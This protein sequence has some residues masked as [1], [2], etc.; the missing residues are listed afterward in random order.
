VPKHET[1]ETGQAGLPPR[2]EDAR[3]QALALFLVMAGRGG[4][5][6]T[7]LLRWICERAL[8]AGRSALVIADGDRTNRSLPLFL[9]GVLNPPATEDAAVWRWLE[10]VL[11][12]MVT[13]RFHLALDL[14]GGDLVLKRMALELALHDLLVRHAITPV[15]LHLLS[16]EVESLAYLASLEQDKLFAPERAALILNAGLVP[17]GHDD[18]AA[19]FER[20]RDHKVFRAAI[21]RGAVSIAMPRLIPAHEINA[22]HISFA[23]AADGKTEPGLPPL[24]IFDRQRVLI[25]LKAMEAAFAPI[26]GWLP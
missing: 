12:T 18:D 8:G 15:V 10:S 16:P 3:H 21:S 14:G 26:A 24:G 22:R 17:R 6:K 1:P 13:D 7:L 20:V 19:A 11:E 9:D 25:W 2:P 5:G 23:D 4:S